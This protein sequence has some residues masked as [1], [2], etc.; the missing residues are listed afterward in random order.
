VRQP[1]QCCEPR[2]ERVRGSVVVR[3]ADVHDGG[4]LRVQ[5]LDQLRRVVAEAV[6]RPP[7]HEV[8]VAAAL[9]IPE[10]GAAATHHH[11]RRFVIELHQTLHCNL[12]H[13]GSPLRRG[14]QRG[15]RLHQCREA[16][17]RAASVTS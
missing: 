7:L 4:E 10:V 17:S 14:R 8:E 3:T 11:G 9:R 16:A 13:R 1:A 5:R 15:S 12:R 6:H 2:R